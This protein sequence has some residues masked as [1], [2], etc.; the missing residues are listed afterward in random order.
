MPKFAAKHK[1]KVAFSTT[2]PDVQVQP[3]SMNRNEGAEMMLPGLDH[4]Q[5]LLGDD[6]T[7]QRHVMQS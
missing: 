1:L 3:P 5:A 7:V 4:L 2:A 6:F